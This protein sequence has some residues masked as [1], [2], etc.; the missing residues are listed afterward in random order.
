MKKTSNMQCMI[1]L[2]DITPDMNWDNFNLACKILDTY[3]IR[4][5]LGVV[6]ECHDEK[7]QIQHKRDSFWDILKELQAQGWMIAQHGTYHMYVTCDSGMLG[8]KNQSEFAGLSYEEQYEKLKTG[9][10][11]LEKN[12]IKTDIFM[13]P[14]HTFDKNTIKALSNLGF[15]T[16]TDGLYHHPYRYQ[17]IV[18]IPCRL[19]AYRKIKGIDT[20]CLHTNTMKERDFLELGTFC[21]QNR[22]QI[23]PFSAEMFEAQIVSRS[24]FVTVYEKVM[25]GIRQLK[26]RI[27]H[28]DRI[29]WYLQYTN[30]E[31]SKKKWLKRILKLPKLLIG[32]GKEW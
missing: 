22:D 19:K 18:F 20:V 15:R 21:K 9:K 14:G 5:L 11:I 30:D 24:V 1:R 8:L 31:D 17:G 7:L 2:D 23:I 25:V 10:E 27:S 6:P 4:P 26:H 16:V 12:G 29:N 3:Q 32:N 13:A 28:S